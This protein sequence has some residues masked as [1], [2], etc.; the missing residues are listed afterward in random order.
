MKQN[1]RYFPHE[2]LKA[3]QLARQAVQFVA[4]RRGKLRG[5]PGNA[6]PQLERARPRSSFRAPGQIERNPDREGGD[7]RPHTPTEGCRCE[8]A[9][10]LMVGVPIPR[11][12]NRETTTEA[13]RPCGRANQSL[14]GR[15][16]GRR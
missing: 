13:T 12:P 11:V 15:C 16:C 2:R 1:T 14:R 3:Y 7:K 8:R 10:S 5:L 6:G 4:A 9:P